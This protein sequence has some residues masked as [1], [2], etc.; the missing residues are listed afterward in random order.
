MRQVEVFG[1]WG[2]FEMSKLA[3]DMY[4]RYHVALNDLAGSTP[5]ERLCAREM[6]A[7]ESVAAADEVENLQ[8]ELD[9]LDQE[10]RELKQEAE[11]VRYE[12]AEAEEELSQTQRKLLRLQDEVKAAKLKEAKG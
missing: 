7:W 12:K 3:E 1:V 6:A 4:Y 10:C 11:E 8:V 2:G 9:A 5:F